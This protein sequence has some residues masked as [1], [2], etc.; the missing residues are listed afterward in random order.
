[1][2]QLIWTGH[3]L[4]A[5]G[6]TIKDTTLYQDNMSSILIEKNGQQ[7]SSKQTCHMNIHYFFIK[8]QVE[9]KHVKI[10]H[11]PTTEMIVDFFT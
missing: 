1:M 11:C 10:E 5:Q 2:L 3:F 9:L 4:D 6:L 8:N 7:S